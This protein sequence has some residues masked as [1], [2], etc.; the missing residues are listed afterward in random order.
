[1]S[2]SLISPT[3]CPFNLG[4]FHRRASFSSFISLTYL[5]TQLRNDLLSFP[6]SSLSISFFFSPNT[7][8][9]RETGNSNLT[10]WIHVLGSGKKGIIPGVCERFQ[11]L[12]KGK[13]QKSPIYEPKMEMIITENIFPDIGTKA[14]FYEM[15]NPRWWKTREGT[16]RKVFGKYL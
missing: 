1:M 8:S 2:C 15:Y 11:N 12:N 14:K 9:E 7:S 6:D 3:N 4:M 5:K 10:V 13:P 16:G